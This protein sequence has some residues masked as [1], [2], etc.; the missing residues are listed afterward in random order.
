MAA[1]ALLLA[2]NGGGV[3]AQ[4]S[5]PSLRAQIEVSMSAERVVEVDG[6]DGSKSS[7]LVAATAPAPGEE[8]VY[9][10]SFWNTGGALADGVRITSPIPPE[11]RY[12]EGTAYGPGCEVLFSADGGRSFG[13]PDE[14]R[15]TD[16]A[17]ARAAAA[18]DY[19]HIR[20]VLATPLA[21]GAKGF[22]RF[23]A[24]GR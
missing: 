23:R 3:S 10:V 15:I 16:A 21:P 1:I 17:G 8:L 12:V 18:S 5:P 13:A 4:P 20:W 19:T 2:G 7:R 9:T 24:V 22:A 14:L 11:A 6:P